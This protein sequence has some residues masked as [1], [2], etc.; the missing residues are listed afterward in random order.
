MDRYRYEGCRR[1]AFRFRA[2]Y[3]S[4]KFQTCGKL[5]EYR[6][7]RYRPRNFCNAILGFESQ[8]GPPSRLRRYG[9]TAFAK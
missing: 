8:N 2:R 1:I 3:R 5:K 6:G 9:A 7:G 4:G